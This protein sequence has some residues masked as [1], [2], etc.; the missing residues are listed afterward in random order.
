MPVFD[1]RERSREQW[2]RRCKY[3]LVAVFVLAVLGGG[4]YL[5]RRIYRSVYVTPE[6]LPPPPLRFRATRPVL[7]YS[8]IPGGIYDLEELAATMKVDP[9]VREHY[10]DVQIDRLVPYRLS[11]TLCAYVSYRI[12]DKIHWTSRKICIPKGELMLTDGTNLI[13][14]R[15]GNRICKSCRSKT[16]TLIDEQILESVIG[17][18]A[19][20]ESS[21]TPAEELHTE[22]VETPE[23]GS[24][25]LC[26]SGLSLLFGAALRKKLVR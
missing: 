7:P 10:A 1:K 17:T 13:R 5:G 19:I 18:G 8:I 12:G 9:V 26:M 21:K 3:A 2:I 20:Y 4:A 6:L 14:A 23:P 16:S 25:L 22:I 15:C 11:E 24:L